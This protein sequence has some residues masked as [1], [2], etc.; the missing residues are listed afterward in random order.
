[1][2]ESPYLTKWDREPGHCPNLVYTNYSSL[3]GWNN[4][5]AASFNHSIPV[6]IHYVKTPF[7]RT[8]PSLV[9]L[10]ND[11]YRE[12][13]YPADRTS[14]HNNNS[15]DS[16]RSSFS[17]TSSS[18]PTNPPPYPRLIVRF[19]DVLTNAPAVLEQIQQCVGATWKHPSQTMAYYVTGAVKDNG[20]F[21]T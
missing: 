7:Q 6:S 16:N 3:H 20:F 14:K 5:S 21:R 19:E 15:N 2:C 12:Y 18:S 10:W 13:L 9:H 17:T 11:W 4:H 1:M 8:W